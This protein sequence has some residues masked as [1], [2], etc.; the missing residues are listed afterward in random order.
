MRKLAIPLILLAFCAIS[1]GAQESCAYDQ[2]YQQLQGQ[3][4][5]LGP[6]HLD[7]I[8]QHASN[9]LA[10]YRDNEEYIIPVV[11][12]ILWQEEEQNL[13]DE[14]IKEQIEVL[15]QDFGQQNEDLQQLRPE[16]RNIGMDARIRFQLVE[17]IRVQTDS[18]FAL[19]VDWQ[20]LELRYP[21]QI[22]NTTT[23][24]STPWDPNYYLNIWVAPIKEDLI[25]GYAY[26]PPNLLNWPENSGAASFA[27][28]GIVINYKAYGANPPP[29]IHPD[30]SLTELQGRTLVHE[31]GHYLGLPHPW[32]HFPIDQDGCAFDD[33]IE[34]TP[35]SS[36]PSFFDCDFGRNSCFAHLEDLPD[37]VENFMDYSNDEC[38]VSFTAQQVAVMRA[39]MA[40]QRKDLRLL[41]AY[42]RFPTEIIVYPNPT[43]GQGRV[44]LRREIKSDYQ[45]RLRTFDREILAIPVV[46]N[47]AEPGLSFTFDL[48]D[49]PNGIYLLELETQQWRFVKRVVLM[50]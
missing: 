48:S 27:L 8:Q 36:V 35:I 10:N 46:E 9:D 15:N 32:G 2:L 50:R 4:P 47:I 18:I 37:M 22:K 49:L 30:G 3:Y 11:I 31:V 41:E 20:T 6:N 17:I 5:A 1:L 34:D 25:F 21:E 29:F 43:S 38:R 24:G 19:E 12:H 33:G 40:E 14:R 44:Y 26:P 7:F 39:V 23:G 28:D 13:S 42:E 16:F 45:F